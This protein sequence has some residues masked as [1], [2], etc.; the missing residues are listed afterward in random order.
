MNVKV[1]RNSLTL[2]TLLLP[3]YFG[4]FATI[5]VQMLHLELRYLTPTLGTGAGLQAAV[6]RAK[7]IAA[8]IRLPLPGYGMA[9]IAWTVDARSA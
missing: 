1:V 9:C 4:N 2:Q 3:Y 7:S 5:D 8:P 6:R